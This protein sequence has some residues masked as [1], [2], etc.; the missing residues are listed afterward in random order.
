MPS[1]LK[2]LELQGY[3]TFASQSMFEFPGTITAVVGPNGSGK[4]NIADALRWV[5]GE[6]SFN[7]LRGKKTEDMIFNGSDLRAK[8]GMASATITFDNADGWLP[9]DFS[10]V[11]ITRR[12]YR[13][14]QNEYLLNGQKVRLREISELLAQS[15][16]AERTYTVI[17]QGLVDAALALRP[18]E[19]RR[20]FEEAAGIGLYRS[21]KEEALNRLDNTRRNLERVQDILAE[22]E[23]RLASLEKQAKRAIEYERI[24]A[25]LRVLLRDWYGFHW[26]QNQYDYKRSLEILHAQ[27]GKLETARQRQQETTLE[28]N[29]LRSVIQ[30]L[31]AKLNEW[32]AQS[33]QLHNQLE[34]TSREMAILSERKKSYAEQSQSI[35]ADLMRLDEEIQ[36]YQESLVLV[37]DER[38][39][40]QAELEEGRTQVDQQKRELLTRQVER[41]KI[42]KLLRE[43]RQMLTATETR[44]I[45]ARAHRAELANRLD[46]LQKS[47]QKSAELLANLEK[48]AEKALARSK[49]SEE[50]LKKALEDRESADAALQALRQRISS[51]DADRRKSVDA[52][53]RLEADRA[54]QKAQLDVLEQAEQSFS[55]YAEGARA[56]LQALKQGQV[57]GQGH[58][59]SALLDIPAEYE[60][61]IAASLGDLQDMIILSG[62]NSLEKTLI[63]LETGGKKRVALLPENAPIP[64]SE[65]SPFSEDN[66][67]GRAIDLIGKKDALPGA[68]QRLLSQVYVVKD[69]Q[70]ALNLFQKLPEHARLVT[71]SGQVFGG[72]GIIYAGLVGQSGTLSRPRQ[73]R[74]LQES[75]AGLE[76][77]I[78]EARDILARFDQTLNGLRKEE[79]E[80][81]QSLRRMNLQADKQREEHQQA[82]LA[83]DQAKKQLEWQKNQQ[84]GFDGQISRTEEE[85][86]KADQ[87]INA[88][89]ERVSTVNA[90]IKQQ[91]NSLAQLPLEELQSQV[92]HWETRSAVAERAVRD[93]D[94]RL[95]EKRQVLAQ[96]LQKQEGLKKR[97]ADLQQM[98]GQIDLTENTLREQEIVLSKQLQELQETCIDPVEQELAE[99]EKRAAQAQDN[100]QSALQALNVAERQYTQ[101]QMDVTRQREALESLRRRIEEDF[102]LV[103]FEYASTVAGPTPLPFDGMVE[104]LPVLKQLPDGLEETIS[105]QKQQLRRMGAVNV[106]AQQEYQSV[107]ERHEFMISQVADLRKADGDLREIIAELDELMKRDF[108][109]TF[110]AVAAEFKVMFS[111]LFA[112]GSAKLVM[113]D[114]NNPIDTGVDIEARL[115]GR[116]EQGLSLLSGG[117][118]SLTAVALV[119]AL[120]K[121]SPTPFCIMD[122]V[123]AMLDESNVNRFC[124][125]L[126]E[127]GRTTQFI[128]ITHN[129]NTVQV[130]D[131]IY[132]ITMGKDSASQVISLKLDEV[133][134]DMG[135][136]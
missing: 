119:F 99:T 136:R 73:K 61:A 86:R 14:G 8:A 77:Q 29:Q 55:G 13:D 114:E 48:E 111:R 10:E 129:R 92:N 19:R 58:P 15:G 59:L 122:E 74:E 25:D 106:E 93:V 3:K 109:R 31:R 117:E 75:M 72:N 91:Q 125:L 63:F 96:S 56:L 121:V 64:F 132:G 135:I 113:I 16:L 23:P 115:P 28:L 57:K 50:N 7:L 66:Y 11:S 95:E 42:E 67:I 52:V 34:K 5:L 46:S 69:R 21:R 120:L 36:S 30:S 116:R 43:N 20:L 33:S 124:E 133:T 18:E 39:R 24:K 35:T 88:T 112:G 97:K 80:G 68:V 128:V 127:L 62:E 102:G 47:R 100:D 87:D 17:G 60:S 22:L 123:D 40:A 90:Q 83:Y 76:Q 49:T 85:I 105:R 38:K 70:T 81:V 51:M 130:A 131:V 4:S 89:S 107:K 37:S 12:A 32:H 118:R 41:G 126:S 103:A 1:R 134:G 98:S 110:N 101:V 108:K 54:R 44:L 65:P 78:K 84:S 71:L 26:H 94:R 53:T 9:I 6:Q 2:S 104:Q 27:E 79:E 82:R 45:Q